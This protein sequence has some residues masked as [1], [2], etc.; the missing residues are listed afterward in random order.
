MM[1][2]ATPWCS[3]RWRAEREW[4]LAVDDVTPAWVP[5]TITVPTGGGEPQLDVAWT[6]AEDERPRP[7]QLHR[8]LLPWAERAQLDPSVGA[9][10]E[11][12]EIAGG[13]GRRGGELFHGKAACAVCHQVDGKGGA[14]GPDLSNLVHR[15]YASV[16]QDITE[17]SA[18]LNP[19]YLAVTMTLKLGGTVGGIQLQST[20]TYYVFGQPNGEKLTVRRDEVEAGST[21]PLGA[22]LMPPGLLDALTTQERKDLLTFLLSPRPAGAR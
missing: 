8:L 11:I 16:L 7:V 22:S 1:P 3:R 13:D 20:S 19:D 18:A 5:L 6:T 17:P 15:D 21:K 12:P 10:G 9:R 14:L 2:R 4:E